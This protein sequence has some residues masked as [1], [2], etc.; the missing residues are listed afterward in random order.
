[1]AVVLNEVEALGLTQ[2]LMDLISRWK[3]S[4]QDCLALLGLPESTKPRALKRYFSGQQALPVSD[5]LLARAESLL[6]I[7]QALL[8]TF[9]HNHA[10]GV[11]WLSTPNR[12]FADA[13]PLQLMR[14]QGLD[15]I[16]QI[17]GHLDCTY[18]WY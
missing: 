3:L 4:P 16:Q 11:L 18:Q 1:M 14:E 15:G 2:Q 7:D 6:S 9:P 8:T 17:R 5:E 12:R 13:A 10:M